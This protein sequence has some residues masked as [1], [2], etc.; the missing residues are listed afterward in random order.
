MSEPLIQARKDAI[1]RGDKALGRELYGQLIAA[2]YR[3]EDIDADT[4]DGN[5]DI[6][7]AF[8][9][10]SPEAEVPVPPSNDPIVVQRWNYRQALEGEL[11]MVSNKKNGNPRRAKEIKAVI[12]DLDDEI[13]ALLPKEEAVPDESNEAPEAPETTEAPAAPEAAV[14]PAPK[15]PGTK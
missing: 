11:G 15:R 13:E 2:G 6:S 10:P 3:P 7:P 12:K 5:G 4:F 1:E 9:D 8:A 14:K